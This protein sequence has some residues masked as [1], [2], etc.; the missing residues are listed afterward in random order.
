MAM[1]TAEKLREEGLQQGLQQGMQQG[2]Q[3]G[4]LEL[5]SRLKSNGMSIE[6]IARL[7]DMDVKEIKKMLAN[8]MDTDKE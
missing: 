6:E 7:T 2:M 1:T 5:M 4:K 8:R 3:Q